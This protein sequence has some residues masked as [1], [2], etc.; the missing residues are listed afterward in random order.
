MGPAQAPT[1]HFTASFS[2]GLLDRGRRRATPL[3]GCAS[4][5][6]SR[7]SSHKARQRWGIL[8]QRRKPPTSFLP[9]MS[10]ESAAVPE[11]PPPS[12]VA[13]SPAPWEHPLAPLI[14]AVLLAILH[15]LW[16]RTHSAPATMSPDSN[17]Y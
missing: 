14:A 13:D 8:Q 15:L 4:F 9:A 5:R 16:V 7:H 2:G 3:P 10:A 17:G 1:L 6:G 12:V 11:T